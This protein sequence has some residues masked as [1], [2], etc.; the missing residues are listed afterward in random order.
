MTG[1]LESRR[2]SRNP[3]ISIRSCAPSEPVPT[4]TP[5]SCAARSSARCRPTAA[6]CATRPASRVAAVTLARARR[7]SPA[8]SRPDVVADVRSAEPRPRRPARIVARGARRARSRVARTPAP[9]SPTR[10]TRFRGGSCCAAIAERRS[11][12][13]LPAYALDAIVVTRLRPSG[14]RTCSRSSPAALAEDL[15]LLG[16]ITSIACIDDD[17]QGRGRVRRP[18][19]RR[20]RRHRGRDR[21]VP[22]GRSGGR[23][24]PG[25]SPTA[26]LRS[27][28]ARRSAGCAVRRVSILAGRARRAEP[29]LALLG[30][31]VDDA[32]VRRRRSGD[33]VRIRD[34][35]KTLP[36][37]RALQRAAVRAG[38]GFNHR[39]S[40]SDAVLIKDNHL[41]GLRRSPRRDRNGPARVG[42]GASSRSSATRSNRCDEAR[43]AGAD[44]VLL[45]NMKPAQVLEAVEAIAGACPVEV[46]GGV[47]LDSLP[48][49]RPGP[50]RLHLDRRARRTPRVALDIGLDLA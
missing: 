34:T 19:S 21:G 42:R 13:P 16:D 24:R 4:A 15:G 12:V 31:R 35:R 30:H 20:A 8:T 44:I 7:R 39:D 33:G 29:P 6:S 50:A 46:S 48:A 45:D 14:A 26:S 3:A 36:G 32:P 43:D 23:G 11:F 2:S 49:L 22:A 18:R 37:L 5:R 9:T 17:Q 27:Q 41:A 38:G 28:P 1:V 25:S 47:T 40:L 10:P